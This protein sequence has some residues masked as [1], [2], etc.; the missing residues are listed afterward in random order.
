MFVSHVLW[1][2]EL[3]GGDL[4]LIRKRKELKELIAEW[5]SEIARL[6]NLIAAANLILSITPRENIECDN[7]EGGNQVICENCIVLNDCGE[8]IPDTN[9]KFELLSNVEIAQGGNE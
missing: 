1:P 7:S 4:F 6:K 9:I 8:V 5:E 2:K 3:I